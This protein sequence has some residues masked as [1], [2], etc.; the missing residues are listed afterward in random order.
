MWFPKSEKKF[1]FEWTSLKPGVNTVEVTSSTSSACSGDRGGSITTKLPT[2]EEVLVGAMSGAALVAKSC[3]T[4]IDGKYKMRVTLIAPY[5]YL[6]NEKLAIPAPSP[7]ATTTAKL[8]KITCVKGKT[9]KSFSG[10]NPKCPSGY[11]QILKVVISK[12]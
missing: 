5:L 4:L 3:G 1:L 6:V 7:K 12:S 10:K 2:S 9:R 8:F 11:R